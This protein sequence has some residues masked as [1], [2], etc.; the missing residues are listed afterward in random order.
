MRGKGHIELSKKGIPH[1]ILHFPRLI[2]LAGHIYMHD[3][4]ASEAAHRLFVKKVMSRVRKGTDY[5]TASSS[6]DWVF[7]TRTWANI[8][9]EVQ[10]QSPKKRRRK[11]VRTMK[12]FV[13]SAKILVPTEPFTSE[14]GQHS[15]SPLRTGGDRLLC[16]NVRMSWDNSCQVILDGTETSSTMLFRYICCSHVMFTCDVHM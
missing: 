10:E 14:T 16:N 11:K 4:T 1:G 2:E 5:D 7:R 15:F 13:N 12:V 8:I 6:V 3:T 9:D